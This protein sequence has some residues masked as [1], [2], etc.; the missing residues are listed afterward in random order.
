M[1]KLLLLLLPL[2]MR[3]YEG[4]LCLLLLLLPSSMYLPEGCLCRL[5]CLCPGQLQW[6]GDVLPL[7]GAVLLRVHW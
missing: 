4:L 1:L 3:L 2:G 5:Y 6:V 7:A